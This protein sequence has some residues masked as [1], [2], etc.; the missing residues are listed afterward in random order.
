MKFSLII[1]TLEGVMSDIEIREKL[2]IHKL[3]SIDRLP[4]LKL[5]NRSMFAPFRILGDGKLIIR[6]L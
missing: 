1:F 4:F 2:L 5:Y 6:T 3:K